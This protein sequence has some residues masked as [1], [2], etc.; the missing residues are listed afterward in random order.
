MEYGDNMIEQN[1]VKFY[2]IGDSSIGQYLLMA[3]SI[4]KDE[5]KAVYDD[6]NDV[7]ELY[8]IKLFF[9]NNLCLIRWTKDDLE[10]FKRKVTT[11]KEIIGRFMSTINDSN[12]IHYYEQLWIRYSNSFWELVSHHNV[13]KRISSETFSSMLSS[14]PRDIE[15]ILI[16]EKLV[17]HYDVQL[18][19]FLISYPKSAEILISIYENNDKRMSLP[20]TLT[21]EDKEDIIFKY[22]DTEDIH[23]DY[24]KIIQHAKIQSGFKISDKTRLKAKRRYE[25]EREE[26]FNG[27]SVSLGG[28]I[29]VSCLEKTDKVK[30]ARIENRDLYYSYSLDFIKQNNDNYSL[31]Q[32][33]I[34]LFEYLDV[35]NRIN[36]VSTKHQMS[37]I[38]YILGIHSQNEYRGGIKFDFLEK[39]S[40]MQIFAYNKTINNLGH[41]L[42]KIIQ[43][44]FCSIFQEKYNFANNAHLSMPSENT[45]YLEKVRLLAPEFESAMK[46]YKL[47]VEDG[48]LDL[49]LLQMTSSPCSLEEIPSLNPYKYLYLNEK[50][51]DIV[52][53][54]YLFF[55]D[56]TMLAYVKPYIEKKYHNFFELLANEQI[57]FNNYAK[58]QKTSIKF[59]IEK[60]FLYLDENNIIQVTNP[61][62]ILILKDLYEKDVVSFYHYT[63][64]LQEE[65]KQMTEQDIT[66]FESTLFSMP[67]QSYFNYYLNKKEFTNGLDLRNS[68]LHG[69]QAN[70]EEVQEHEYAYFTYLKLLV[71]ALLKIEDDL[72]ISSRIKNHFY[73]RQV[74]AITDI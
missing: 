1:R 59:L 71:L 18:R 29:S 7:I 26:M 56:Q 27:N 9:D 73:L 46:Q 28:K 49:E 30:D 40:T 32:N 10:I 51:L 57:N 5:I 22:I 67:E 55:S 17:T 50:N 25:K 13:Y 6:I 60:G 54:S 34:I 19:E 41:S 63:T 2:S 38:E 43:I 62:R 3:E 44:V 12:I 21:D 72:L 66:F 45:S 52:G 23:L 58:Y 16:H 69:T 48:H 36:F 8:N 15:E 31:F 33:F 24:L 64:E 4:L 53:C 39:L 68:Y 14:R 65:A 35:Q 37:A 42:E 47:F 20:K 61:N 11:Y 70:P 74:G